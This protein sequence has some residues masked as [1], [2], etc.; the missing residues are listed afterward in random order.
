MS[1]SDC[2]VHEALPCGSR[3]LVNHDRA[4]CEHHYEDSDLVLYAWPTVGYALRSD[5]AQEEKS[6]ALTNV[7]MM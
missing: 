7:H 1:C 3:N 2:D 4:T 5:A 6:V